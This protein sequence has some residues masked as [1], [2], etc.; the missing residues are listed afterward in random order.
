MFTKNKDDSSDKP[1]TGG[2]FGVNKSG[3][4]FAGTKSL[5]SGP[6]L[7]SGVHNFV[8]LE[9]QKKS[10]ISSGNKDEEGEGEEDE[11]DKNK[12]AIF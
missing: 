11:E 7:F 6:S 8:K 2:L 4:L 12:Y 5:F 9:D 1:A 10:F 3:P